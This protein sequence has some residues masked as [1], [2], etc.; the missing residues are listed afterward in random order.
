VYFFRVREQKNIRSIAV[1]PFMNTSGDPN[2]DYLSDGV[3]EGVINSLSQLPQLRVMARSTVFHYKGRDTDPQKVGHDLNVGAV[4]TGTFVQHGDSV[5]VQTEL[6]DVGS[7]SELWGEQYE[8]KLADMAAV[9]QEIAKDISD[10]LRLRLTGEEKGKLTKRATESGEAYDLYLKGRYEWNKR[11]PEGLRKAEAFFT[12]AIDKDPNYALA[13]AG[14]SDTYN[15]MSNY[16][17]MPPL[18][19]KPKAKLAAQKAVRLDDTLCEAH[20]S[21]A[22]SFEDEWDWA[23]AESEYRRAIQLNPSYATAHHWY[24]ILLTKLR[25]LDEA[26]A[27]TNR[28]LELDPLS[29]PINQNVG[30]VYSFMRQD[31]KA[32]A[33]YRKTIAIDPSFPSVHNSLAVT[34]LADGKYSEGF[35]ELRQM[36]IALHDPERL[37][38]ANAVLDVFRKSGFRAA[39]QV[40]INADISRSGREYVSP[41]SIA[42]RYSTLGDKERT[43][44]WLQKAYQAGRSTIGISGWTALL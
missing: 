33:Q 14:L 44:E 19:A 43:F 7:G 17:V 26:L 10:R 24:S 37:N 31:A 9:Q 39:V 18:E 2:I 32:I 6:V 36:A 21:L 5:R 40:G 25:R 29:L 13:Y 15:V 38:I 11:T 1:L 28:A 4:L 3:T 16:F 30:D 42:V 27:A 41:Y 35:S 23:K 34:L 8:R 22:S 20:T 12:S